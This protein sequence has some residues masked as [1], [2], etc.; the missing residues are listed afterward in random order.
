MAF[1]AVIFDLDGTLLDTLDDLA[2]S[3]N[4]VLAREN[5]PVHPRQ[6][7]RFFVGDGLTT[8]ISRILPEQHRTR[9][10]ITRLSELFRED[11]SRNWRVKSRPYEGITAMLQELDR[12]KISLNVLSNKPHEF[13]RHCVDTFFANWKFDLVFGDRQGVPRKP[14]PAGALQIAEILD[15]APAEILYLGD[16]A[17]D[18]RCAVSAGMF[19]VGALWGFRTAD[20][21]EDSGARLLAAHPREVISAVAAGTAADRQ[22]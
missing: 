13:T 19:P 17:T 20:E 8:L 1:Q 21:L 15:L 11:Y 14:D 7:Y 10:S 22:R 2:D 18:M 16:T 6:A 9:E 12:K 3:A 4:R 5:L